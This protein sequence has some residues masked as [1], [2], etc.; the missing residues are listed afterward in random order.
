M[1]VLKARSRRFPDL[2]ASPHFLLAHQCISAVLGC[3]W[4]PVSSLGNIFVI[5]F[6]SIVLLFCVKFVCRMDGL[7]DGESETL[8]RRALGPWFAQ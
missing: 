3:F 5:I 1:I 7:M 6:V 2:P 4:N 8:L